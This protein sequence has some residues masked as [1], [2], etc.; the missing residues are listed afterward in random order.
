MAKLE[1]LVIQLRGDVSN[2]QA[3]LGKAETSVNKFSGNVETKTNKIAGHFRNLGGIVS[4]YFGVQ[5]VQSIGQAGMQMEA[6]QAKMEAAVGSVQLAGE[7]I[8]FIRAESERLGLSFVVAGDSFAGF[9]ASAM[10]AGL[11]FAETKA[12]FTGVAE[13][14]TAMK[15][16]VAD[17]G[18]VFKALEQMVSKGTVSME[19]LRGQL[20]ERLPGAVQIFAQAMGVSSAEFMKMVENGE[21]G[22]DAIKKFG[23]AL[24]Q[25]FGQNAVSAAQSAQAEVNRFKNALNELYVTFA[26]SGG[27]KLFVALLDILKDSIR[28]TQILFLRINEQIDIFAFKLSKTWDS[29]YNGIAKVNNLLGGTMVAKPK[30]SPEDYNKLRKAIE[31]TYDA[32][33]RGI[34]NGTAKRKEA[35]SALEEYKRQTAAMADAISGKGKEQGGGTEKPKVTKTLEDDVPKAAKKAADAVKKVNEETIKS[36]DSLNSAALGSIRT[37]DDL[38][39]VAMNALGEIAVE[40]GKTLFSGS[41]NGGKSSGGGILN[42]IFSSIGSNIGSLFGRA[43]GGSVSPNTPYMV[44][45]RGAELFVPNVGGQIMNANQLSGGGQSIVVNQSINLSTGVSQTVRAELLQALPQINQMT[46]ASVLEAINNG[47]S[48]SRAVGRRT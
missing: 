18:L 22:T 42:S 15:L 10:R 23:A 2:L 13:A 5:V 26:N 32:E 46:K 25:E 6:L 33:A 35:S 3:A 48:M 8:A 21:V 29:L 37:F 36:L 30:I 34:A 39:N 40:W 9:A 24:S 47:G 43:A 31:D 11:T 12:I 45:E 38:K 28:G 27:L 1:D 7:A 14:A 16:S 44:G 19:E 4:A 41:S 17:Q 20:G